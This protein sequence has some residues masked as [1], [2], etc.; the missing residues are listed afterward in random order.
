MNLIVRW[1]GERRHGLRTCGQRYKRVQSEGLAQNICQ[2]EQHPSRKYLTDQHFKH[3]EI[4]KYFCY[5]FADIF[6]TII[7]TWA[8]QWAMSQRSVLSRLHP[9][10]CNHHNAIEESRLTLHRLRVRHSRTFV[11]QHR[12]YELYG[13]PIANF[14]DDLGSSKDLLDSDF[15][16][17][18]KTH[19]WV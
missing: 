12:F 16:N 4:Q 5:N 6:D 1:S 8:S 19:T 3:A 15:I 7:I 2:R 9:P 17:L 11:P 13:V 10:C 14:V 18:Y